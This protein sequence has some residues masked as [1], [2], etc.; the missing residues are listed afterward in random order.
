L[1]VTGPD[2]SEDGCEVAAAAAELA[3]IGE[4]VGFAVD[5]VSGAAAVDERVQRG[6]FDVVVVNTPFPDALASGSRTQLD[7]FVRHGGGL[8]ISHA[9]IHP[10]VE[11]PTWQAALAITSLATTAVRTGTDS[12]IELQPRA[13]PITAAM[14]L[15]VVCG[16]SE[17]V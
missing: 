5:V 17:E 14:P 2:G 13:H 8:I 3:V 15:A 9:A 16:A 10:V 1:V 12:A 7:A 11:W 6:G 4:E